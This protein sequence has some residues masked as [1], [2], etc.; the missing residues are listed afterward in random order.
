LTLDRLV[1]I[2][3]LRAGVDDQDFIQLFFR[4][5]RIASQLNHP[6][7]VNVIDF[8]NTES[9]MVFLV[10]E[11]LRGESLGELV[12]KRGG[13]P[14]ENLL[15]V[16]EQIGA[17]IQAA[18]HLNIVHRDL[19]PSNVVVARIS[20]DAA[21]AK[22]LDFG[23][24][25]PLDEQDMKYTRM[26]VVM[27]TPGYLAPEQIEG[28]REIDRR[29]DIYALG[30]ILYFLITAR[31]PYE[32]ESSQII[33]NKQLSG[34]P[35]GLQQLQVQDARN[36]RFEP[37]VLKAM[38]LDPAER[39]GQ[40]S[41]MLDDLRR[42]AQAATP[43][44]SDFTQAIS[45]EQLDGEPLYQYVF[46]GSVQPDADPEEVRLKLKSSLNLD[47][48]QCEKLFSGRRLV[49]KRNL[50][51]LAAKKYDAAFRST[52]AL[53][54]IEEADD[55]TRLNL[56]H[57]RHDDSLSNPVT[58]G[59]A[60][61]AVPI[62]L[63]PDT[64]APS[65]PRRVTPTP[66]TPVPT[67]PQPVAAMGPVTRRSKRRLLLGLPLILLAA[68]VGISVLV[69]SL[70]Y[71]LQDSWMSLQGVQAPRGVHHDRLVLGMSAG[72]SASVRELSRSMQ[73]GI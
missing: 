32:G 4:E 11:Y 70:R 31:R 26:G 47:D 38:A 8:G 21:V 57:R 27:G 64:L 50:S 16:M 49:V 36:R 17:G 53:G 63:G 20:G 37:I 24:S 28:R 43:G 73:I 3:L 33:M 48:D 68:V 61:N 34:P 42:C 45:S 62:E 12:E 2:K 19:K 44:Q 66:S 72:F 60:G 39:Y 29:A 59:S 10:L 65:G 52:G 18:H 46:D 56:G 15:W 69:P 40:V 55:T 58:L 51:L 14:L 67:T 54:H 35:T 7:V 22:I 1:A 25:K 23:I 13:L 6:N 9:G 5:A 30:A 71:Y 41:E